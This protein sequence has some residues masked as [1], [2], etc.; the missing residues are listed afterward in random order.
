MISVYGSSDDIVCIEGDVDD[1]VSPGRL[2]TIGDHN[3]GVRIRFTYAPSKKSG[4]VWRGSVEQIDEGVP[5]FHVSVSEADPHGYPDPRSYS[6]KLTID[7]PPGTPVIV[8]KKNIAVR[9][10]TRNQ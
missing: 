8:G 1:E 9:S 5:M 3:R 7:C 4:A 10:E 2:I 6:V